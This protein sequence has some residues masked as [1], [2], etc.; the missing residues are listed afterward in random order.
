[1]SIN[2]FLLN[3]TTLLNHAKRTMVHNK[4]KYNNIIGFDKAQCKPTIRY[5]KSM[6][7]ERSKFVLCRNDR[8]HGLLC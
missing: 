7:V 1:M 6:Y 2:S 8:N 4:L 5:I 3:V